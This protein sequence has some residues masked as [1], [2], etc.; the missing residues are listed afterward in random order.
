MSSTAYRAVVPSITAAELPIDHVPPL[1]VQ[2]GSAE[3]WWA[4]RPTCS[5]GSRVRSRRTRPCRCARSRTRAAEQPCCGSV[6]QRRSP[7]TPRAPRSRFATSPGPQSK[8]ARLAVLEGDKVQQ[9]R[10]QHRPWIA[11]LSQSNTSVRRGTAYR[12]ISS[13]AAPTFPY[14][15][16]GSLRSDDRIMP[17]RVVLQRGRGLRRSERLVLDAVDGAQRFPCA[18]GAH[19]EL[20]HVDR[21]RG[22]SVAQYRPEPRAAIRKRDAQARCPVRSQPGRQRVR[23]VVRRRRGSPR[24]N[25]RTVRACTGSR[26]TAPRTAPR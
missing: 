15:G 7:E 24:S 20:R 13:S 1:V 17:E 25:R 5:A 14:R 9:L 21:I 4:E 10:P 26:P 23:R 11:S 19:L 18:V 2:L 22:V 8:T 12:L 16:R 3:K 6:R